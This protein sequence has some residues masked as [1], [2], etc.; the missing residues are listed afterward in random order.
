MKLSI[1]WIFEH[2][3]LGNNYLENLKESELEKLINKFS[4]T[5]VEVDNLEHIN[6][7]LDNFTLA[8]IQ[9]IKSLNN[10]I[11]YSKELNQEIV[12]SETIKDAK[13]GSIYL[14]KKNKENYR[15]ANLKD[16][17]ANNCHNNKLLPA[18]WVKEEDLDGSWKK[19]FEKKDYILEISNIA[20]NNRPDLW[21]HRGFAREFAAILNKN[22]I[23][24]EQIL[25]QKEIRSS[26]KNYITN[27]FNIEI[28]DEDNTAIDY[29]FPCRRLAGLYFKDIENKASLLNIATRL[30]R[31]DSKPLNTIVDLTNY[32]MLDLSQ[33]LHAFDAETIKTKKILARFA[34]DKE[35]LKL[36]DQTEI[37]LSSQDYVITDSEKP[38]ALAGIKGGA[39]TGVSDLTKSI[40]LES[41]NFDPFVIRSTTLNKK[42]R[43]ESS[44]R[45]EK[46]LDP[47]Q[48]TD[49]IL[50]FLKLLDLN[51]IK[52][53]AENEILSLGKLFDKKTIRISYNFILTKLGIDK[54]DL[55]EEKIK[56]ILYNLEFKVE[57]ENKNN[58]VDFIVEIPTYRAIKDISIK[59]DIVKEIA[60]FFGYD[61]IKQVLPIRET[62]NF[63]ISKIMQERSIKQQLAYGLKMHEVQTY[64]FFDQEFLS[65]INYE[66]KDYLEIKNPQSQNYKIL[67]TTLIPN[68]L[69]CVYINLDKSENLRFF[70]LNRVWF[71]QYSNTDE[72]P[73]NF[74]SVEFLELSGIFYNH[75]SNNN[76]YD[77]K[78]ELN[79]L[80]NFLGIENDIEWKKIDKSDLNFYDNF[81]D[82]FQSAELF[83]KNRSIGIFGKINQYILNKL[84]P[85][86]NHLQ[87]YAFELDANFLINI[88]E[89]S[90]KFKAIAKY[91]ESHFD[92]SL[93][94]TQNIEVAT[95]IDKIKNSSHKIKQV[96][97]LDI[98]HK[99]DWGKEKSLT[100]RIKIQDETKTLTKEEI[101]E[102]YEKVINELKELNAII[103]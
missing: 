92:I 38:I 90:H 37:T 75:K 13:L 98:F 73:D 85:V 103:R 96:D 50:R 15:L 76:F 6:I 30:S 5:A 66:P 18:L 21:G 16:I 9:S 71:K 22:L 53:D 45:F 12:L 42:I 91:P 36:L 41:A 61:N 10:L 39:E 2:I 8:K 40:F 19:N 7:D 20:I 83:Y 23:K 35:K 87:A 89:Q 1:N 14:L 27:N 94:I 63:Q 56:D 93:L 78:A 28:K 84:N 46:N 3:D 31:V 48:N 33:P 60:R 102:I 26:D 80:F 43:T 100:F 82:H 65:L 99:K 68:L 88:K 64:A 77:Y 86:N 17:G 74:I 49:A 81:Y 24:T 67:V 57:I 101:N 79:I 25:A 70:E 97:L 58:N 32:V 62:K 4:L 55:T 69:K 44:S 47:N 29:K 72:N 11:L 34:F 95:V 51:E 54:N 59:E 52:Y